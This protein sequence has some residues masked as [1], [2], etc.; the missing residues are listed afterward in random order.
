MNN[1]TPEKYAHDVTLFGK[2]IFADLIK[3]L[4]MRSSVTDRVSPTSFD[5]DF[6]KK[7]KRYPHTQKSKPCG[8]RDR[9]G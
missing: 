8:D 4:K 3:D 6:C 5:T 1:T 9:L 7:R 2:R